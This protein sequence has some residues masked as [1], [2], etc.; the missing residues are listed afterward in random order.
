[1]TIKIFNVPGDRFPEGEGNETWDILFNSQ[2][3]IS[4]LSDAR[5]AREMTEI[6]EKGLSDPASVGPAIM[7]RPD[8][9]VQIAAS[10]QPKIRPEGMSYYSQFA[11]RFGDYVAKIG[12]V[13]ATQAQAKIAAEGELPK[14]KNTASGVAQLMKEFYTTNEAVY[15]LKFQLLE[16]PEEQPVEYAGWF[17]P[18]HTKH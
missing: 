13:P 17:P 11:Y 8:V 5:V 15:D 7:K 2:I 18:S 10:M 6:L 9:K 1:M 12:V 14:D 4:E 16:N 3:Q